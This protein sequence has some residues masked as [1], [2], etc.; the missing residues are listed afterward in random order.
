M[1]SKIAASSET[2]LQFRQN[3]HQE[4]IAQRKHP[5]DKEDQDRF[6]MPIEFHEAISPAGLKLRR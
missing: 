1:L 6:H 5:N 3:P 4:P 2:F